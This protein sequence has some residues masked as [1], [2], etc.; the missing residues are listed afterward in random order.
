MLRLVEATSAPIEPSALRSRRRFGDRA[1]DIGL[2]GLTAI[3]AAGVVALVVAIAYK[4]FDGASP[5]IGRFGLG[6]LWHETWDPVKEVFGA[7]DF[8]YGTALT[9]FIAMLLAAPISIAIALYLSELAP[10]GVRGIIGSL[11]EMLAAVPSVVLGLWGILVLAPFM[12]H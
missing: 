9:S 5:A 7:L 11:V 3:A 8:I 12:A 4:I 1:A 2:H 10:R 6:F